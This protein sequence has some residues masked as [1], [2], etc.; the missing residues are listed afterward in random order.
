[1][2]AV[3]DAGSA[4]ADVYAKSLLELALQHNVTDRVLEDFAGLVDLIGSDSDFAA[5]MTSATI[6]ADKRKA[7]LEK[8]FSGRMDDVLLRTLLVLNDRCRADIVEKVFSRYRSLLEEQQGRVEVEVI[9]AA[10]MAPAEQNQLSL[11][12][13]AL[14]GKQA[15]LDIQ[16]DPA[17]VGGLIV[18]IGDWQ[19]DASVRR[20]LALIKASLKTR[21]SKEI[22]S[23]RSHFDET[24]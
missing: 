1:M 11:E 16:I 22:H 9:A 14:T 23:G 12:I 4:I 5:F 21:A 10:E 15:V 7:S 6:D 2:A 13:T 18:R 3:K 19:V 24:N 17:L 20:Q 8:I